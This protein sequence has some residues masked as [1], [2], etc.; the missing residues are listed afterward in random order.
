MSV[1]RSSSSLPGAKNSLELTRPL[2]GPTLH[3]N[4]LFRVEFDSVTS[5]GVHIAEEAF[6]PAR[7]GKE[8]HWRRY[9]DVDAEVACLRLVAELAGR[10]P[11]AREQAR[12][13]AIGGRVH[14]LN[15]LLNR[16]SLHQAE[17]RPEDLDP[18]Q[19]TA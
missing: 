10:R 3:H 12:H 17:H 13:V 1:V 18:G 7:E 4:L 6:L 2:F 16:L 19:F 8:G 5:L 9:A 14:E 11:T 15:R